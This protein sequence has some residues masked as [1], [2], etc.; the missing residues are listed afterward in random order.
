[1]MKNY[2]EIFNQLWEH[3]ENEVVEFKRQ[4]PTSILTSWESISPPLAMK[5]TCENVSSLG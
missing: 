4:K 3:S 1:M 2:N 5:Q